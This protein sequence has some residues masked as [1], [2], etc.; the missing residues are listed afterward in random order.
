MLQGNDSTP[1]DGS[2]RERFSENEKL[3]LLQGQIVRLKREL[4]QQ[5]EEIKIFTEELK[6]GKEQLER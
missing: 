2:S 6:Q 5:Q 3:L 4:L 1:A